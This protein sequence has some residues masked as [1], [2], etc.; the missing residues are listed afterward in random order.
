ME[1]EREKE[2]LIAA[3][4]MMWGAIKQAHANEVYD[5][6]LCSLYEIGRQAMER[7]GQMEVMEGA[8]NGKE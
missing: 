3:L 6:S 7:S 4:W 8:K 5:E 1:L 2:K